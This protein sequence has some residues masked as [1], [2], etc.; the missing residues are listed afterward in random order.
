MARVLPF[1]KPT[2]DYSLWEAVRSKSSLVTVDQIKSISRRDMGGSADPDSL[3]W[4]ADGRRASRDIDTIVIDFIGLSKSFDNWFTSS[5]IGRQGLL[6]R[7]VDYVSRINGGEHLDGLGE[8]WA[9]INWAVLGRVIGSA[10]ANE[11]NRE[12]WWRYSGKDTTVSNDFWISMERES[13]S[14]SGFRSVD[15]ETWEEILVIPRDKGFDPSTELHRHASH[16]PSAPIF[17][18]GN[19]FVMNPLAFRIRERM[20]ERFHRQE[21][22]EE[23]SKF[24]G[25]LTFGAIR[26]A[27]DSLVNGED[28]TFALQIHGICA[29]HIKRTELVQQ[30]IGMHL[31]SNL[32]TRRMTRDVEAMNVPDISQSLNTGF[33]L[34]KVLHIL[35][36]AGLI[37]WYSVE[38]EDV[39]Q[40]ISE[41]RR[42]SG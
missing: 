22:A 21:D 28:A 24:H 17:D 11:G 31:F 30:K 3:F 8:E 9:E 29:T 7:I 2:W 18:Y 6:E 15:S 36:K 14:L 4:T 37:E 26:E 23:F 38:A 25:N 33:S 27:M 5:G 19:E 41:L 10:I 34:G 32:A 35:H 39:Y 13:K 1:D 12:G 42:E 40:A 20:R 16:R